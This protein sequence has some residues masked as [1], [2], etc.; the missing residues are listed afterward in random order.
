MR[1]LSEALRDEQARAT[2]VFTSVNHPVAGRYETVT[3]PIRLSA[4][5]MTGGRPAPAL[6]ADGAAIL[7]AAGLSPAEIADALDGGEGAP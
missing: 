6:N 2:G 1:T 7:A 3:A 5:D 4:H